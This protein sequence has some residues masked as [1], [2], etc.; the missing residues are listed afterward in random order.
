MLLRGRNGETKFDTRLLCAQ[1][2][3]RP[4]NS[5]AWTLSICLVEISRIFGNS[6]KPSRTVVLK[7]PTVQ[8]SRGS[9]GEKQAKR[10]FGWKP[11]TKAVQKHLAPCECCEIT[12]GGEKVFSTQRS[13]VTFANT[14]VWLNNSLI[15]CFV[16]RLSCQQHYR[17]LL[18]VA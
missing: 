8:L 5:W 12:V 11:C 7:S 10:D 9:S 17:K 6:Y 14:I 3:K 2:T 15:S 1:K 16:C 13:T 18:S 4:G